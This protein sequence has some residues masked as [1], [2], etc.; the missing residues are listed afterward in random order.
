MLAPGV[1]GHL[2]DPG[3]REPELVDPA[4]N[5]G[6][7]GPALPP[8]GQGALGI[9]AQRAEQLGKDPIKI[10]IA[11]CAP[12]SS[13]TGSLKGSLTRLVSGFR[14]WLWAKS[15]DGF[16]EN[17]EMAPC[18][19]SGVGS[20]RL[21]AFR[22]ANPISGFRTWLLWKALFEPQDVAGGLP[23]VG[24]GIM[25]ANTVDQAQ[26]FQ[27]GQMRVQGRDRHFAIVRQ[28]RLRRKAAEVGVVPVA[29]KPQHDLWWWAS[30]RAAGWPRRLPCGSWGGPPHWTGICALGRIR[31]NHPR[32]ESVIGQ[33]AQRVVEAAHQRPAMAL[34]QHGIAKRLLRRAEFPLAG[35]Q[36]EETARGPR[37]APS[38]RQSPRARPCRRGSPVASRRAGRARPPRWR[39]DG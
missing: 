20:S 22:S 27:F 3:P 12:S 4:A 11:R 5:M 21:F 35:F 39:N 2:D 30:A 31:L 6:P 7:G 9:E 29:E 38:D 1:A 10:G 36:L 33:R 17:P 15:G 19:E 16:G 14:R 32:G 23:L 26:L 28:P 8:G 34:R 25:G 24:A 18:P 13:F 37:R